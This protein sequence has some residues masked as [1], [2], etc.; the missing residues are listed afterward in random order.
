[1]TLEELR[2]AVRELPSEAE[3]MDVVVYWPWGINRP[4]DITVGALT[5]DTDPEPRVTL[6]LERLL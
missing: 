3:Y 6:T 4:Q 5:Y 1:M 2:L